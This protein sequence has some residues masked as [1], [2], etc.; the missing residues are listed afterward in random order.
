MG[1]SG[2]KVALL[3]LILEKITGISYADAL[4]ARIT[5]KVGLADTYTESGFIDVKK[6]ESLTY[7]HFGG[8]WKQVPEAHPSIAYGAGQIMS[9]PNKDR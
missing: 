6:N 8:D 1:V 4:E 9:T 5:S 2:R 7:I 3:T